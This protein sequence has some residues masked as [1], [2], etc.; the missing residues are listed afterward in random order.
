MAGDAPSTVLLASTGQDAPKP[1]W[2]A[3]ALLAAK[4]AQAARNK[5]DE[6]ELPAQPWA[7]NAMT[8]ALEKYEALT[9]SRNAADAVGKDEHS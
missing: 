6:P 2:M 5:G 8:Q 3:D 4:Q 1:D 7:T 9:R